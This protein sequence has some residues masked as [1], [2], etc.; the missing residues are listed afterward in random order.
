MTFSKQLG[1]Y[2][3][4]VLLPPLGLVPGI[5][6]LFQ[7]D[8]KV[9]IVGV[10]AILL[11]ILSLVLTAYVTIDFLNRI[12]KTISTQGSLYKNLGY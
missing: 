9:K 5:K 12:N 8:P 2:A 6:Y 7:K 10:V 4:S 3:L 11:T 1:V